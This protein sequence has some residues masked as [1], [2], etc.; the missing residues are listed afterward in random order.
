MEETVKPLFIALENLKS[1]MQIVA[2]KQPR[3]A[4]DKYEVWRLF[5]FIF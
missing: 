1:I 5:E 3:S 4:D 2:L